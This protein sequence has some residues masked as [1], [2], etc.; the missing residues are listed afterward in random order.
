MASNPAWAAMIGLMMRP[1]HAGA[2]AAVFP[3]YAFL[4]GMPSLPLG[5]RLQRDAEI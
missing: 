4:Q 2:D 1:L 3:A 5:S